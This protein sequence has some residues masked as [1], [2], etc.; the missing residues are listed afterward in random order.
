MAR[1]Q[2]EGTTYEQS[3]PPIFMLT[4]AQRSRRA[5]VSAFGPGALSSREG[6]GRFTS[7]LVFSSVPRLLY[8]S[9]APWPSGAQERRK[10]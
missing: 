5:D 10:S 8:V 1:Q 6:G 3:G 4:E 9:N 7:G 2:G